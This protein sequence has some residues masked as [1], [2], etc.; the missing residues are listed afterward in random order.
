M[1]R[2]KVTDTIQTKVVLRSRRRCALCA[3][4]SFDYGQKNGQIA[5]ID[6]N[7]Q[8]NDEGNLCFLCIDHHDEYDSTRRQSKG[9][10][11]AELTVYRDQLH[12]RIEAGL[13]ASKKR[14]SEWM[15]EKDLVSELS[16]LANSQSNAKILFFDIRHRRFAERIAQ[17]FELSG[18][19]VNFN[20]TAQG[21]YNPHYYEGIEIKGDY[22][23]EVEEIVE[24]LSNSGL[25]RV[26]ARNQPVQVPVSNPKHLNAK[27][28]VWITI[29]YE[30]NDA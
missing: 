9:L 30:P 24:I 12:E 14:L 13:P 18:W 2:K 5:H 11:P 21:N 8:N 16:A 27:N 20:E 26:R 10:T 29:G 4:L 15:P 3:G 7:P 1:P 22:A 17:L 19:R 6:R 23:A 25:R 28:K